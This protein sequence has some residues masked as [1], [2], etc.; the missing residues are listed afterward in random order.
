MMFKCKKC[1]S[2][3]YELKERNNGTGTATGLYCKECGFWHKWI[4]KSDLERYKGGL[5]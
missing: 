2:T 1:G 4:A 3:N 5:Y